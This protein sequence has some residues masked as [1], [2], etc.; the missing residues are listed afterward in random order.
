MTNIQKTEKKITEFKPSRAARDLVLL[1]A[2]LLIVL[3]LSYFFDVFILIVKF[4]QKYPANIVYV[5]EVVSFLLTLSIGLAI[6]AWRRWLE[7]K[8]ETAERIKKQEEL[9][10][11]AD[12]QA[13]VERIISKQLRSDMEQLKEDVRQILQLLVN[14]LRRPV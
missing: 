2:A 7:L 9:I 1:A 4:L 11:L 13:E 8:K 6:F 12:T 3:L 10:R 5:D 14:K